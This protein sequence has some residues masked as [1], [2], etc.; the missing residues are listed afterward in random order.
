MKKW[1]GLIGDPNTGFDVYGP[2]DSAEDVE[3]STPLMD[4]VN[5]APSCGYWTIEL[6]KPAT[7]AWL[8]DDEIYDANG[9][10]VAFAG[11]IGADWHNQ[12]YGPFCDV[13]LAQRFCCAA[14]GV[15]TNCILDLKPVPAATQAA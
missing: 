2:Y 8:A 10:I 15:E 7:P 3:C 4:R 6:Q 14:L 13:E 9:S 5:S 11:N 12:F 1:I